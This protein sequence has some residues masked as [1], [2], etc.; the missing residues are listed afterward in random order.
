MSNGDDVRHDLEFERMLE[1]KEKEGSNELL[2]FVARQGYKC[3]KDIGHIKNSVRENKVRSTLNRFTL[4]V[5]I[6]ILIALGI[7]DNTILRLM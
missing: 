4:I 7:L 2:K 5:L 3:G 6:L 1:T